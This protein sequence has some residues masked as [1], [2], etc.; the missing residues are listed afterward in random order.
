MKKCKNVLQLIIYL[1]DYGR[2]LSVLFVGTRKFY[3]ILYF[4]TAMSP[5]YFLFLLQ[6][7]GK[8]A[9]VL[10]KKLWCASYD[11]I[12]IFTTVSIPLA[13]FILGFC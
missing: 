13:A 9:E 5:A 10:S 4:L 1:S 6:L 3:K 2:E 7:K 11:S 12:I 8:Y